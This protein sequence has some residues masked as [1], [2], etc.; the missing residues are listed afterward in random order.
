MSVSSTRERAVV[1]PVN[2][3]VSQVQP[4][5]RVHPRPTLT[6]RPILEP[7]SLSLSNLVFPGFVRVARS[8]PVAVYVRPRRPRTVPLSVR[9]L[10]PRVRP[11]IVAQIAAPVILRVAVLTGT[12][13]IAALPSTCNQVLPLCF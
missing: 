4:P 9:S 11:A 8:T 5:L 2:R 12:T 6:G 3:R 13:P 10:P 7:L 1:P